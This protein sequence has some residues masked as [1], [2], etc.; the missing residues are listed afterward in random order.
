MKD[1]ELRARSSV[2]HGKPVTEGS[3]AFLAY[4]GINRTEFRG[5]RP[6]KSAVKFDK[7]NVDG[8]G[9]RAHETSY[10]IR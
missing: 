9:N 7:T 5:W 4:M 10:V 6:W 2:Y 1:F 3:L 8:V